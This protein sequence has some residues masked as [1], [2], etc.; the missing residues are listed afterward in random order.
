MINQSTVDLL[1]LIP[2]QL[3]KVS[4]TGGG[5]YQGPCPFCG[6]KDRF[7]VQPNAGRWICRRCARNGDAI[8]FVMQYQNIPFKEAAAYLR[9]ELE[10][11]PQQPKRVY[12]SPQV[13]AMPSI[14]EEIDYGHWRERARA[15]VDYAHAHIAQVLDYLVGERKLQESLLTVFEVGYNPQTVKDTWGGVE[16]TLPAGIVIPAT[17]TLFGEVVRIKIRLENGKAKYGQVRGSRP[18][19]FSGFRILN[20]STVILT[21]GE[22]DAIA[23]YS[24]CGG[25]HDIVAVATGST[26]HCRYGRWLARL[27][28]ARRV[29]VAFDAD[30]AGQEAARWW[31]ARLDNAVRIVP[32]RHDINDMLIA[33]DDLKK[34]MGK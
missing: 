17:E 26:T 24:A 8:G 18:H 21:E 31:M 9:L 15:F 22:F 30:E 4:N 14:N 1:Q 20:G 11:R 5:E 33:G 6:G 32:T 10:Q 3:K 19:L 29:V 23:A 12:T 13:A 28:M 27:A 7:S 25:L 2:T 34:W 16:V